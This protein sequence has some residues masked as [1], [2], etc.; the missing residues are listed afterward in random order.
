[1]VKSIEPLTELLLTGHGQPT[2][3]RM[4]DGSVISEAR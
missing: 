1:M 3:P 2:V 4:D